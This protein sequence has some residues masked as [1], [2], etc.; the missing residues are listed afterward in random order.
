M[1]IWDQVDFSKLCKSH[2]TGMHREMLSMA[3]CF[4][5]GTG[6]QNH[7]EMVRFR[8]NI[9]A[10][11]KTHVYLVKEAN[12]RGYNFKNLP[13]Y[14]YTI[15]DFNFN[16]PNPWDDQLNKLKSKNCNCQI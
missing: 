3:K 4:V 12:K 15:Q 1:R 10:F 9:S 16:M 7:P 5:Y 11:I 13:A 8:N 6:Y 14:I 2:L